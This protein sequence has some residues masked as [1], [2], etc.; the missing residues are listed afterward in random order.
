MSGI[1]GATGKLP[2]GLGE[3]MA[4]TL[5]AEERNAAGGESAAWSWQDRAVLL[6]ADHRGARPPTVSADGR[7]RILLSGAL[8]DTE[9]LRARHRVQA[10]DD[11]ML[12]LA[13][14]D[15][16]GDDAFSQLDGS[17][18]VVVHDTTDNSLVLTGDRFLSRPIFWAS[19]PGGVTFGSRAQT[20]LQN[21]AVP[22]DLDMASVYDLL[23]YQRVHATRTL[24]AAVSVLPGATVLTARGGQVR[25]RQWFQMDYRPEQRSDDEWAEEMAE[26]FQLSTRRVMAGAGR[27]GLLLSGGL[28]SRMIAAAADGGL[29][30]LHFNENRNNREY[31]TAAN[32]ARVAGLPM[33]Y[34]QRTAGHYPRLLDE[35]VDI[36]SGQ[37]PFVHAHSLGLLPAEVDTVLHGYAPEIWFRGTSLPHCNRTMYGRQLGTIVDPALSKDNVVDAIV[38]K[39]KYAQPHKHPQ[40]LFVPGRVSAFADQVRASAQSMVTDAAPHSEDV[41]DW[42]TWADIR[43]KGKSPSFLFHN[44]IRAEHEERS[45][46]FHNHVLDLHLRMPTTARSDSRIWNKAVRRLSPKVAAVQDANTGRSPFLSPAKRLLLTKA[47]KVGRDLRLRRPPDPAYVAGS[48]PNFSKLI[49]ND[50]AMQRLV[51]ATAADPAALDPSIFDFKGVQRAIGEHLASRADHGTMFVVLVTLGCWHR[52]YGP[53]GQALP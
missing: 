33:T 9:Q 12:V 52:K 40:R 7:R 1:A 32:I 38:A 30:A 17:F 2:H 20:V 3:L 18:A 16:L 26:A 51:T 13:L 48:W 4:S 53:P 15:K 22:R 19:T 45:V 14:Y 41:Y 37:H 34:L 44:S 5:T 46:L 6:Q 29:E 23:H 24:N 43:W 11:A 21:R 39:L 47:E 28:D 27:V 31:E 50:P 35:A 49:V 25:T 42:F 36:G 8:Y 10:G